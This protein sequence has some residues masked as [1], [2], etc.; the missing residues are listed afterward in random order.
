[1]FAFSISELSWTTVSWLSQVIRNFH[2]TVHQQLAHRVDKTQHRC[3]VL[4]A[5][6]SGLVA[7]KI[8]LVLTISKI[9]IAAW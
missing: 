1:M 6:R 3:L 8:A 2:S 4:E 9:R 5:R 7:L